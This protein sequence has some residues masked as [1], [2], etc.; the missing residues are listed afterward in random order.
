MHKIYIKILFPYI[1][2]PP[3]LFSLAVTSGRVFMDFLE[4][5]KFFYKNVMISLEIVK[6]KLE[7]YEMRFSKS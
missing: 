1:C 6:I 3:I 7:L 5:D 2:F 4:V